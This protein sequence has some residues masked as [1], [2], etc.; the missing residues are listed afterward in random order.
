MGRYRRRGCPIRAWGDGVRCIGGKKGR[1]Y[2]VERIC[3]G[4]WVG[5]GEIEGR[6]VFILEVL[7]V[8]LF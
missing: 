8:R 2:H 6:T 3:E 5:W 4:E 7:G 1:R